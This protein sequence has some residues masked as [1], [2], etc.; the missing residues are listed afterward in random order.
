MSPVSHLDPESLPHN[1]AFT[2]SRGWPQS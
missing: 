2:G 1:P